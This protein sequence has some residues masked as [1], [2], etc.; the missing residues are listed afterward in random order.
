[1]K[2]KDYMDIVKKAKE[3]IAAGDIF[4]A[5]LSQRVSASIGDKV[6]WDLYKILQI[7]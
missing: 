7:H 2:K 4:Q 6:A 5:N 1:M 3:Y